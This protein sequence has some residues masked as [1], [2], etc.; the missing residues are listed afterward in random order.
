MASIR[1]AEAA[2]TPV[3]LRFIRALAVYEKIGRAHV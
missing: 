1:F 3:I 2:D